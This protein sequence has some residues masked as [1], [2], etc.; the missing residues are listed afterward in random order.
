MPRD[1][2]RSRGKSRTSLATPLPGVVVAI[3]AKNE[4]DRIGPCLLAL[5]QQTRHPDAVLLLLNGCTDRSSTVVRTLLPRLPYRLHV[6]SHMFPSATAN[7]GH[8]RRLAMQLAAELTNHDGVLLTTDADSV[9]ARNWIERNLLALSAGADLVCGR[10]TL[11]PAEAA[12]IPSHLHADDAL[13]CELTELMDRLAAWLDPDPADPW[14]RH[15]EQAGA[16]LA[17]TV[18]AFRR[19]GGIP[20]L[21]S[22]EDRAFVRALLRMDARIR[23]DPTVTVSVS[24]RTLGRASG[25]MADT[26]RRRIGQQDEFIDDSVE[27]A[28]DAYRRIDFR[29]RVRLAWREQPAAR[30]TTQELAVDLGM[31][32]TLLEQIL[33]T[34][35]FGTAWAEIEAHS[36]FL[37]R[38]RLRFADLPREIAYARQLLQQHTALETV[39]S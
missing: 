19:V 9:V 27:P 37:I 16:S 15:T 32:G 3:P 10:V 25:G 13:E 26:I 35:F 24:G 30:A 39:C 20:P 31:P 4:A 17:V 36:P 8:A 18:E 14:P 34:P 22:G 7:A 2:R 5:A 11:D 6:R 23:H 12:L 28:A 38:R 21:G 29:R 33:E 1:G